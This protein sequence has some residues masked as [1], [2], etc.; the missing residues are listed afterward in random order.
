M[1]LYEFVCEGCKTKLEIRVSMTRREELVKEGF[2]CFCGS[3][4]IQAVGKLNFSLAG[5]GWSEH[6]YGITEYERLNN[7]DGEKRIDDAANDPKIRKMMQG[8]EL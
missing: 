7:L 1:P 3:D 8:G 4:M 6:G 5:A 2:K